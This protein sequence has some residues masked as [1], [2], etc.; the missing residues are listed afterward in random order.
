MGFEWD[1]AAI[2]SF[3]QKRRTHPVIPEEV[4]LCEFPYE[5][6]ELEVVEGI[7]ALDVAEAVIQNASQLNEFGT[8]EYWGV[9][10]KKLFKTS[11]TN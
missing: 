10:F 2:L 1:L 4:L 5:G 7:D 11:S 9:T 6:V 3:R 8:E